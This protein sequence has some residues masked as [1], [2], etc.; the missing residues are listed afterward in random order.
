MYQGEDAVKLAAVRSYAS[1]LGFAAREG[2][3]PEGRAGMMDCNGYLIS[4]VKRTEAFVHL[5]R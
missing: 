1:Q 3:L 2:S 4:F 5:P